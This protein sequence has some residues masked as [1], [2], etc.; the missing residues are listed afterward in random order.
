MT[1]I[2]VLAQAASETPPA[3][4]SS[5]EQ[6]Y[7]SVA[8]VFDAITA[9]FGRLDTLARPEP[10]MENLQ[11]LG[12]V[13]AV[14]FLIAGV[15]CMLNGYKFQKVTITFAALLLGS[16]AGYTIGR[17]LMGGEAGAGTAAFVVAGLLGMLLAVLALPMMKAAI[18]LFGGLAGAFLGANL[19]TALAAAANTPEQAVL[20]EGYFWIGAA[21]GAVMCGMLAL[22][23]SDKAVE[24]FSSV[25]GSTLAVFGGVA[26]LL[27]FD[28][29]RGGVVDVLTAH[30]L[31]VPL[32]VIVPAVIGFVMQSN[33]EKKANAMK[34]KLAKAG[35]GGG[36]GATASGGGAA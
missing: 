1:G 21:M 20:P 4:P 18:T 32:L 19:W 12:A 10:L 24:L 22:M 35:G 5:A 30:A 6:A 26:L 15:L 3:D 28:P 8:R 23:L 36:G 11:M 29:V 9:A 25:G 13:W 31:I 14:V 7:G 33:G 27:S 16:F 34:K 2:Y 17:Q